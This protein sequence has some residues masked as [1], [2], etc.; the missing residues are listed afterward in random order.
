MQIVILMRPPLVDHNEERARVLGVGPQT[1]GTSVRI[2]HSPSKALQHLDGVDVLLIDSQ[3]P[4]MNGL[5]MAQ[6]AYA[7]GWR[8]S[9][10]ITA[11]RYS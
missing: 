9:L 5:E 2:F 8:G 6:A 11:G 10:F 3:F 7:Q 4:E 1:E